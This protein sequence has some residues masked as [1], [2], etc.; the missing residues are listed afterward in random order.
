[1]FSSELS[2]G[3]NA[4]QYPMLIGIMPRRIQKRD[5]PLMSE[6]NVNILLQGDTLMRTLEKSSRDNILN[7]LAIYKERFDHNEQTLINF[8][9]NDELNKP[10]DLAFSSKNQYFYVANYENGRIQC[11]LVNS[12]DNRASVTVMKLN[13]S[14]ALVHWNVIDK[15]NKPGSVFV[16]RND[17]IFVCETHLSRHLLKLLSNGTLSTVIELKDNIFESCS[18]IN[19][20]KNGKNGEIVAGDNSFGQA[21][22]QLLH[23]K[24]IFVAEKI[25]HIYVTDYINQRI[26]CLSPMQN[27]VVRWSAGAKQVEIIVG[28]D[29][30]S[31]QLIELSRVGRMRFDADAN[32]YVTDLHKDQIRKFLIDN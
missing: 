22:N 27:H 13:D 14:T 10:Y 11:Y 32:L 12:G 15:I 29:N 19:I 24:D 31:G 6:Y 23:P 8:S 17:N 16:D 25:G 9:G 5:D 3:S 7:E 2:V 20:D 30:N 26:Q 4:E 21:S 18:G 1:M 28:G